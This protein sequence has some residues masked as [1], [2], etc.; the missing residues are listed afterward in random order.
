MLEQNNTTLN[1][2]DSRHCREIRSESQAL[3]IIPTFNE[4]DN[5]ARLLND[6]SER[7]PSTVDILVIDDNSPDGTLEIVQ[8]MQQGMKGL[9]VIKRERKLGLGT[10]YITGFHY[11][12]DKGYRYIID[13]DA[14]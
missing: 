6:L 3:I 10:A 5:I 9:Q 11:A 7:Y 4:A 8:S 14:A 12:L 2:P 1:N 13:L